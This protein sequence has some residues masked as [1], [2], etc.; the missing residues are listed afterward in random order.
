MTSSLKGSLAAGPSRGARM[1]SRL[2]S[3]SATSDAQHISMGPGLALKYAPWY[4]QALGM[5]GAMLFWEQLF[6]QNGW[7][8]SLL[9]EFLWNQHQRS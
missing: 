2:S 8:P 1:T 4:H 5:Q 9:E 3:L 7:G 6:S